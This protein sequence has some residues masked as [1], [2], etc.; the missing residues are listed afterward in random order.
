MA[1]WAVWKKNDIA[2]GLIPAIYS[3]KDF[4]RETQESAR[5]SGFEIPEKLIE[6]IWR[7]SPTT[8]SSVDVQQGSPFM[9]HAMT[10]GRAACR[11]YYGLRQDKDL[12]R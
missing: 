11:D 3:E 9:N 1:E 5:K 6:R 8:R 10:I 12:R 7:E 2:I 4:V